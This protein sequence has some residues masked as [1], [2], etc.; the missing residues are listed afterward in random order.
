MNAANQVKARIMSLGLS[1]PA[2]AAEIGM[3]RSTFYRKLKDP[4]RFTVA[5]LKKLIAV[6][7]MPGAWAQEIFLP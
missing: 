2:V 5:E 6:L 3:N 1:I 4:G 7:R